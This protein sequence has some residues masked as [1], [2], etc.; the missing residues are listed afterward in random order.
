MGRPLSLDL[1]RRIVA[2]VDSGHSCRAAADRFDVSPSA[3]IK[4]MQ[5]WRRTG[6][7]EPARQGRPWGSR[8]DVVKD[9]LVRTVEDQADITMPELAERLWTTHQIEAAPPVL[10]RFLIGLGFSY[11]SKE[12]QELIQWVNSPTNR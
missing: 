5:L 1:R 6:S 7:L 12:D 10:S 8:L 2:F 9:F 11:K 4:L 3:A